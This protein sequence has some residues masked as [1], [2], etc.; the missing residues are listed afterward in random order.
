MARWTGAANGGRVI[1]TGLKPRLRRWPGV[2]TAPAVLGL[3][4]GLMLGLAVPD[5][6]ASGQVFKSDD[7][8]VREV[9]AGVPRSWPPQ[10][11]VDENGNPTGFAIDVMEEIAARAGLRVGY[12]V[13]DSFAAV[14]EAMDAGQI[15][16]MPN[17]GI[18]PERAVQYDFTAPVETLVISIFVRDDTLEIRGA[19]Q[20]SGHK[21]G[22]V[23]FNIGQRLMQDRDDLEMVV[24][25]DAETA[26]FSLVAGHVDAVIYPQP[27]LLSLARQIG[28]EDRIAVVG[29]PL[30]E[31]KRGI[32][33]QKGEPE[34]LAALDQ[35]VNDFVGTPAYQAIYIKW[36]GRPQ[37]FWT[38]WRVLAAT[39]TAVLLV[40]IVM[41]WWRYHSV[42]ALNR[43]LRASISERRNAELAHRE[44]ED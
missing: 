14:S 40:L 21:V 7:T 23:E 32:R 39:S 26:L 37:P 4:L 17:S 34:L 29:A 41:A 43:E 2:V 19:G 6:P 36:Y 3:I 8:S 10:Y 42:V 22:V 27:V 33:V 28:I 1:S 24:Y 35:A 9:I 25:R 16:L 13:M 30:R 15:D 11:S 5:A 18:T 12:R 44:S 38:G 31:I 20:L